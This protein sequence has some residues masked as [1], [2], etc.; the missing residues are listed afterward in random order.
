MEAKFQ[1]PKSV[2]ELIAHKI[3]LDHY[4]ER[5]KSVDQARINADSNWPIFAKAVDKVIRAMQ[6]PPDDML[7]IHDLMDIGRAAEIRAVWQRGIKGA[8]A[9]SPISPPED[10]P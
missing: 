3:A 8:L 7:G 2:V 6:Y 9:D 10:R 5:F 1:R 4:T